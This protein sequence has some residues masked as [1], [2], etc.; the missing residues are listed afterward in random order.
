MSTDDTRLRLLTTVAGLCYC[1]VFLAL[2]GGTPG[3]APGTLLSVSIGVGPALLAHGLF[4]VPWRD[5]G[6]IVGFG[7][8]YGIA[9]LVGFL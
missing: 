9:T 4:D 5:V 3:T 2:D 7:G 1:V 6:I 8:I